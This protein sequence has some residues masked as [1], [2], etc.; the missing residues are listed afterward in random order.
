[1]DEAGTLGC[2]EMR[3]MAGMRLQRGARRHGMLSQSGSSY[4]ED[5]RA[6]FQSKTRLWWACGRVGGV[7]AAQCRMLQISYSGSSQAKCEAGGKTA[8]R[9]VG[10]KS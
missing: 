2:G 9:Q 5:A 4:R 3:R 10:E 6:V 7:A 1:M 8:C